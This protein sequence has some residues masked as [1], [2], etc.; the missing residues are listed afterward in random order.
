MSP[1]GFVLPLSIVTVLAPSS[2]RSAYPTVAVCDQWTWMPTW[3]QT[4]AL[5]SAV[6]LAVSGRKPIA[7]LIVVPPPVPPTLGATQM[8]IAFAKLLLVS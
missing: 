1:F 2:H 5:K 7:K 8:S 4:P 3:C 6:Q